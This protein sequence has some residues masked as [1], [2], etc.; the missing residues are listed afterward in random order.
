MQGG[1]Q[2]TNMEINDYKLISKIII[3]VIIIFLMCLL[4]Y[5]MSYNRMLYEDY[6]KIYTELIT[7]KENYEKLWEIHLQG[8]EIN[9]LN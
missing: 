5:E 6:S 4:I 8:V 9:N 3:S 7:T 1:Q 2:V